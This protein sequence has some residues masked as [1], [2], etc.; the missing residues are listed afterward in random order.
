VAQRELWALH[1]DLANQLDL[2]KKGEN[3]PSFMAGMQRPRLID[4]QLF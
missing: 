4:Q 2:Q 1:G 3:A